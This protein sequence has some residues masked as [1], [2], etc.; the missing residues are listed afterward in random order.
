MKTA[1]KLL[2]GLGIAAG[3]GLLAA[4]PALAQDAV[5]L[6]ANAVT[7]SEPVPDKGDTTWMIISTM[8]VMVMTV[9]GLALFYGGLVRTKNMLSI[10]TQVLAILCV[11]CIV[12][13]FWGY[14][15][16]FTDGANNAVIGGLSKLFLAGVTPASTAATFTSGVVIPEYIFMAFQMTFAAITAAL[17]IGSLA[18]RI[19]FG[20]ILA[21]SVLWLTIVYA[22]L[23]HMVW[24][25]GGFL[26]DMGALDFAGG[27]VVHI[28]A[29]IAGLVGAL[30]LGKRIG[31]PKEPMPPH[32]MVM[33][34][35][36]VGL[37]WFGWFGF[38]AGSNLEA[39]GGTTLAIVNTF[40]APASAGLVWMFAE[41]ATRGKPSLLGLCSGVVA[42]LVAVTPAAG[43]AGPVGAIALG[44]IGSLAAFGFVGYA[45]QAF[46]LDD[47]LDVF[48]IHGVAGIVGSIL[49]GVFVSP[50][51]GG[52]GVKDYSM[53]HQ[54]VTQLI[55]VAVA[56]GWSGI[57]SAI[58]YF[59]IDKT[60]GL[61][62]D[63]E[64][65]IEGLDLVSHGE[66]AYHG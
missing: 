25:S 29:G 15:L 5:N 43:L 22:P 41:W 45:K 18:E 1:N 31:F 62:V 32:S 11:G 60:I 44:A 57:L 66:R 13:I 39:T 7:A 6:G 27:T 37:V 49:T 17:V 10:L 30:F 56:I 4:H 53:G 3:F 19:K 58:L 64:T 33:T 2:T 28:N 54:V 51:L 65:E 36:G 35:I 42:G 40:A 34:L 47:S 12:W 46:G 50:D 63:R 21:F 14:S 8:V 26:F 55:A 48:G 59:I 20:A 9:P 23:A 16:A 61:R 24:W 52:V 38:N